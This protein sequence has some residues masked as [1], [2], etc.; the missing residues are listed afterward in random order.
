MLLLDILVR[1]VTIYNL[2]DS[3]SMTAELSYKMLQTPKHEH[4]NLETR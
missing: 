1:L 3:M 2:V 4:L